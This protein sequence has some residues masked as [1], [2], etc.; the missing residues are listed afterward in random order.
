M[1]NLTYTVEQVERLLSIV[2]SIPVTGIENCNKIVSIYQILN[3]NVKNE[4]SNNVVNNV[5][6][7]NIDNK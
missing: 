4:V 2:N 7:P 3:K 1:E 6:V 5:P